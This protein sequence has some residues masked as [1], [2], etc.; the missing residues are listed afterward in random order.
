MDVLMENNISRL[1]KDKG[2]LKV[3]VVNILNNE[4]QGASGMCQMLGTGFGRWRS[5]LIC[6]V[7]MLFYV[8]KYVLPFPPRSSG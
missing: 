6:R 1:E 2:L 4:N 8:K 3:P 7:N 5:R